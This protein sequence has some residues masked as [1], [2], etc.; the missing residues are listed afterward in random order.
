ML[1]ARSI[2]GGL[3]G[4]LLARWASEWESV[5]AL[6]PLVQPMDLRQFMTAVFE[7]EWLLAPHSSDRH[8]SGVAQWVTAL[9]RLQDVSDILVRGSLVSPLEPVRLVRHDAATGELESRTIRSPTSAHAEACQAFAEGFALCIDGL[10][11]VHDATLKLGSS[12]SRQLGVP[13][14]A[15]ACLTPPGFHNTSYRAEP[16]SMLVLQT[17][18]TRTWQLAGE[19]LWGGL[20]PGPPPADPRG[21]ASFVTLRPGDV[22]YLPS[23]LAHRMERTAG[24]PSL[25]LTLG[26]ELQGMTWASLM[27]L[28][29]W[30]LASGPAGEQPSAGAWSLGAALLQEAGRVNGLGHAQL[31][32]GPVGQAGPFD[33]LLPAVLQHVA[34]VPGDLPMGLLDGLDRRLLAFVRNLRSVGHL[35]RNVD[36]SGQQSDAAGT[37]SL[38]ELV[39]LA[40]ESP[41]AQRQHALSWALGEL[42][43]RNAVAA[44]GRVAGIE[45]FTPLARVATGDC[46]LAALNFARAAAGRPFLGR[47]D[48]RDGGRELFVGGHQSVLPAGLTAPAEWCLGRWAG[49][50][51]RPFRLARVPGGHGAA[52]Q[53]VA[54]LLAAGALKI[55][56]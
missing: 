29:S 21:P 28:V 40:A 49:A 45:A 2:G 37:A 52:R 4:Q 56:P 46:D 1:G 9:L 22:L 25:H 47:L 16:C 10:E 41:G 13:V 18:G 30:R 51:G 54:S 33:S 17:H 5:D 42:R 20:P 32:P 31:P 8:A 14:R 11:Q 43:R 48:G 7:Q 39:D 35:Q 50:G 55:L 24:A 6:E 27:G 3:G 19:R 36:L 34:H 12:L 23:W 15:S 53:T 44:V 26:L 38:Q